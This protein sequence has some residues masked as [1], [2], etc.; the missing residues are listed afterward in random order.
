MDRRGAILDAAERVVGAGGAQALTLDAVAQVA[1]VSK[2][3]LLHHFRTKQDLAAAMID[4]AVARFDGHVA[5]L[6][7][8]DDPG[9]GR[10]ARAYVTATL[11]SAEGRS[12]GMTASILTALLA[13]P[14]RLAALRAQGDRIQAALADDGIDPV[15]ATIVRL[16]ADGL[17]LAERFELAHLDPGLRAAV[18]AELMAMTNPEGRNECT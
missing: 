9:P 10:Q 11:E 12:G 18:T 16:A 8:G 17:W 4:R 5:D 15:R 14:D 2:G 13:F 7:A 6:A 3:G 1:Q